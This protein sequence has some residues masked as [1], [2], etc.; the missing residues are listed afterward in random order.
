[1][2]AQKEILASKLMTDSERDLKKKHSKA[3]S[4]SASKA[5]SGDKIRSAMTQSTTEE[6][7]AKP[8]DRSLSNEIGKKLSCIMKLETDKR[9]RTRIEKDD[10]PP[11]WFKKYM[12]KVY[13]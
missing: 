6:R 10:P 5:R 11:S 4:K 2:S 13:H 7:K 9:K 3:S 8:E 1:V 12:Q